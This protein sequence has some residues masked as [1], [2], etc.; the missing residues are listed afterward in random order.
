MIAVTTEADGRSVSVFDETKS[1]QD[2]DVRRFLRRRDRDWTTK[3]FS[4]ATA[5]VPRLMAVLIFH[6]RFLSRSP[7]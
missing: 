3:W 7:I 1:D 6:F 4:S 2:R 5:M